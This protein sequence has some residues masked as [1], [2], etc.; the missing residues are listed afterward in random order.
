MA[1]FPNVT[2]SFPWT[3][4]QD[5]LLIYGSPQL[6][7]CAHLSP[8]ATYRKIS[9]LAVVYHLTTKEPE[10]RRLEAAY[11][12][13]FRRYFI[14]R[15]VG[16][17]KFQWEIVK[18]F[19]TAGVSLFNF[20]FVDKVA[21]TLTTLVLLSPLLI[22][23]LYLALKVLPKQI[24]R[25]RDI[26]QETIPRVYNSESSIGI[27]ALAETKKVDLSALRRLKNQTQGELLIEPLTGEAFPKD[28]LN[29][30]RIIIVN[31]EAFDA[32]S[33]LKHVIYAN[34]SEG[35][36]P[37]RAWM[38]LNEWDVESSPVLQEL[39]KVFLI[40]QESFTK[41]FFNFDAQVDRYGTVHLPHKTQHLISRLEEEFERRLR[42][43]NTHH[44]KG[45]SYD[46]EDVRKLLAFFMR[47]KPILQNLPEGI[48]KDLFK[49][50]VD[51]VRARC[52][53]TVMSVDLGDEE[54]LK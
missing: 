12:K 53:E 24:D 21:T 5:A 25:L 27:V 51:E 17:S 37:S 19:L 47:A 29:C 26:V 3:V 52:Y 10:L 36:K 33:L 38:E 50:S 40:S 13:G 42:V 7:E 32:V 8:K 15:V 30:P 11:P 16:S 22:L 1:M 18:T 14:N 41:L 9:E 28:M 2:P 43:G 4:K 45:V 39:G 20:V 31:D 49:L 54:H 6:S 44:I 48:R 23:S 46:R 34:L 35:F